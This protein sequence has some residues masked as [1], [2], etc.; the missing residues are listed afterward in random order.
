M[1]RALLLMAM[2]MFSGWLT[3]PTGFAANKNVL[4]IGWIE[5][6]QAGMNP[7]L[8]RNMGDYFFMSLMYEPLAIPLMDGTLRPWLAKS[9]EYDGQTN[10]WT[11][12]LDERVRWSDGTPFT[13]DDVEFTYKAAFATNVAIGSRTKGIVKS[14]EIVDKHTVSFVLRD[15]MAA[16]VTVGATIPIMPKHIWSKI[17]KVTEYTNPNPVG[18]GP[19]LY[20]QFIPRNFLHLTKNENYWRGPPH[21]DEVIIKIYSN[22]QAMVVALKKGD[23]DII[24]SL[25]GN[26]ALI[27]TLIRDKNMEVLVERIS[28]IQYIALNYRVPEFKNKR[29]RKAIDLAVD[30]QKII[31]SAMMGYAEEPLMGY[32]APTVSKWANQ[33][34]TWAGLNMAE[35]E[36]LDK[37]NGLLDELG[38]ERGKDG[39]RVTKEGK[40][41][42]FSIRCYTNP[43]YIRGA[44]LIKLNL[45]KIGV[46]INLLVS[47]PQ[48]LYGGIVYSGKRPNDWQMMF[49][50]STMDPDPDHFAREFAPEPPNPWDNAPAFGWE[51]E[52]IQ[53]ML[54]KSRREM[55]EAKRIEMIKKIQELFAEELVVISLCHKFATAAYRNDKYKGWNP[56]PV[57]YGTIL[58]PLGSLINVLSLKPVN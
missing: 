46:K 21:I 27:P 15:P 7:F 42:E 20:R 13:A 58:N 48:T 16:F 12:H 3:L 45:E 17:G 41:L 57:F 11:F 6:P 36:R 44:E 52:E 34:V 56:E 33:K 2:V 24:P 22:P 9:W 26:E 35:Q 28:H 38:W 53:S 18:T 40:K 43:A 49:H 32:V 30:K 29:F 51:N 14:I 10:T 25:S 1:K 55:N 54:R 37:A 8:S 39:L 4:R 5:A 23:L 19:F 50:G 47:D 31:Q